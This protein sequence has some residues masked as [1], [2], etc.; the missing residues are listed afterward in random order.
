MKY[1]KQ[2]A[3]EGMKYFFDIEHSA[4]NHSFITVIMIIGL[5]KLFLNKVLVFLYDGLPNIKEDILTLKA[6]MTLYKERGN[7]VR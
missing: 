4:C 5:M 6:Q 7:V 2:L 1:L 3:I